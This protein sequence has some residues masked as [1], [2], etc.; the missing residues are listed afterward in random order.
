MREYGIKESSIGSKEPN[1]RLISDGKQPSKGDSWRN[2]IFDTAQS[3]VLK[4]S[5]Y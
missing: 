3:G 5:I 1:D 2:F 4:L